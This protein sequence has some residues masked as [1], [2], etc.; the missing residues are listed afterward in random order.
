[1]VSS[2][3]TKNNLIGVQSVVTCL[4][5]CHVSFRPISIGKRFRFCVSS[6]QFTISDD[7]I[8]EILSRDLA[9][10][11]NW[12]KT[13]RK[14]FGTKVAEI[15][16]KHQHLFA[17][18]S[19]NFC[20]TIAN[21]LFLRGQSIFGNRHRICQ[22]FCCH[23]WTPTKKRSVE[24][25]RGGNGCD[26]CPIYGSWYTHKFRKANYC[27]LTHY[28]TPMPHVPSAQARLLSPVQFQDP[29]FLFLLVSRHDL[30]SIQVEY[31]M[32][33]IRSFKW[34]KLKQ[35]SSFMLGFCFS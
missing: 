18:F 17:Y 31:F 14:Y 23:L 9:V 13:R 34:R 19:I 3:Y 25:E 12:N 20:C 33:W 16:F 15:S 30:G 7:R 5:F 10:Y 6:F 35:Q 21:V 4:G 2:L 11:I 1:M 8:W 28:T 27:R 29:I 32:C 24:L 26:L 22:K